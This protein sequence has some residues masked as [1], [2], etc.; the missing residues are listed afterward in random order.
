MFSGKFPALLIIGKEYMD[1]FKQLLEF[2]GFVINPVIHGIAGYKPGS[3]H[4]FQDIKLQGR[5]YVGE[6][7]VFR[8]AVF[9][10]DLRLE[11]REDIKVSIYRMRG[12][13]VVAVLSLPPESLAVIYC[14]PFVS[15][16][17]FFSRPIYFFGKSAPTTPTSLALLNIVAAHEKYTADPPSASS[18]FPEG[19][20]NESRAIEPTTS[21][22]IILSIPPIFSL[23]N[24]SAH[25]TNI[26]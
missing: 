16:P 7:N 25:S 17:P 20:F 8:T 13:K 23:N 10:G 9:A 19:V 2:T 6:K 14:S 1:M 21:R 22:D 18:T 4:L 3:L 26:L 24:I 11:I 15:T 12:I 5:I